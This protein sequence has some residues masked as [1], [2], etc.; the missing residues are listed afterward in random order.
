MSKH[1]ATIEVA[2]VEIDVE[3]EYAY[4][5]GDPGRYSGPPE[6]CYPSEPA[7]VEIIAVMHNGVDIADTLSEQLT[8]SIEE[9]IT[10]AVEAQQAYDEDQY[11]DYMRERNANSDCD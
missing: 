6:N 4:H 1:T 7:Y 3:V 8:A 10:A 9:Q 11:A 2:E 5:K